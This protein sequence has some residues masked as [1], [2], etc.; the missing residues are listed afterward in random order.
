MNRPSV[1]FSAA[2]A[3]VIAFAASADEPP[4]SELQLSEVVVTTTRI[5]RRIADEPTRVEVI[6]HE[7]L[8]EKVAMSPGDVAMLFNETSGL[9]VQTTAPGLGA[10]NVRIQGLRGRYSQII[11]DGLPLYGGQTGGIGLLQIPPLDLGQVEILKGVASALYGPSA[12]GGVINLTARR[13]DGTREWLLNETSRAGTDAALWWASPRASQGWSYSVLAGAD[14]QTMRDV[15]GDGWADIPRYLRGTVRPRFYWADESGREVFLTTGVML[16]DR[17]GGTVKGGRVPLGDSEGMSFLQAFKT[18]RYDVGLTG[19]WPLS[20]ERTL[21]VR[22]SAMQRDQRQTFGSDIEPTRSR[23][24][25]AEAALNGVSALHE[26]V[27]GLA[28]EEDDYHNSRLPAFDFAYSAPGLFLQDDFR[29]SKA[30][31]VSASARLDHHNVYGNFF[32]PRLAVL[33]RPGGAQSPWR[34][35][36]ALGT[37]FFAPTPITEETEGIG[38]AH[39][40]APQGLQAERARGASADLGR[41][42]TLGRGSMETNATVFASEIAHAVGLTELATRPPQLVNTAF[43]TRTLGTE[44]L[45]RWR[46][47]PFT[48]TL[49]HAY[50][51]S[52]ELAPGSLVRRTVQLNPRHAVNFTAVWE[53]QEIGRVGIEAFYTGRQTLIENPYRS[54]SPGFVMFGM[55]VQRRIGSADVFLNAENLTDRRLTRFQPLVLPAQAPD[56]RWTTDAW[57]PLDGRVINLGMRWRLGVPAHESEA[58]EDVSGQ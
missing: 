58:D 42:W 51:N 8:E 30:L 4:E 6:G 43:P 53:R 40:L 49:A 20:P 35:R 57:G 12:L 10:A 14:R 46:S 50:I 7:E 56:G 11:A 2:C 21:T 27:M 9:R 18:Q 28:F 47:G 36:I 1:A 41:V 24:G 48:A 45:T 31:T 32:S 5:P 55:L 16:E 44:L 17:S 25:F 3:A 15:S 22:A 39:L 33:W 29:A 37:G 54:E 38:L 34:S 26:W 13:P 52:S 19:R 23:T